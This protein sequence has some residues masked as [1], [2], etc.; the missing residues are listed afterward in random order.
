[1]EGRMKFRA[2]LLSILLI[3]NF[4]FCSTNSFAQLGPPTLNITGGI[5]KG[6][7]DFLNQ[8]PDQVRKALVQAIAEALPMINANVT[9]WLKQVNKIIGDNIASGATALQCAGIGSAKIEQTE[10]GTSLA[11][12]LYTGRRKGLNSATIG[13][14]TQ[15][16]SDSISD[17]RKQIT[18]D[19]A[20][21][22]L[23]VAY[24]DLLIR[25]AI[26]RCAGNINPALVQ[27][28]LDAQIRRISIPDLE[29]SIL[30]G[31]RDKP[32]CIKIH[33]C[34]TKRREDLQKY[35][36]V[37]DTRDKETAHVKLMM[38]SIPA[39]PEL[40]ESIIPFKSSSIQ[41]LDYEQILLS[42]R[43]VERSVE[44]AKSARQETAKNKWTQAVQLRAQ[45]LANVKN[46]QDNINNPTDVYQDNQNAITRYP[47]M[48]KQSNDA[49][50]LAK[51]TAQQDA[52]T[53][54]P[55]SDTLIQAMNENIKHADKMKVAAQKTLQDLLKVQIRQWQQTRGGVF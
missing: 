41:I 18:T 48:V 14:Y 20:A 16:L 17:T 26:V 1:M 43:D 53:Y 50:E 21:T 29:W 52:T 40:P 11:N 30:I 51:E 22:E 4:T 45:A 35:L 2:G 55:L 28:E 39:T 31:D 24:S 37:A 42:L 25:A 36:A 54:Q 47:G 12:I 34:V 33:D 8:L 23:L 44:G 32:Y 15:N 27:N 3:L 7:Q 6:T 13:N 46:N 9:E 10:L 38:D 49:I 5:D 19:T